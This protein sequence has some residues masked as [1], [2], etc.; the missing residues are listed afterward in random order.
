MNN[1]KKYQDEANESYFNAFGEDDTMPFADDLYADG[2]DASASRLAPSQPYIIKV[3]NTL[4]TD[5]TVTLFDSPNSIAGGSPAFGNALGITITSE[6][7]NT[8]YAQLL[9]QVMNQPFKVGRIEVFCS[10]VAQLTNTLTVTQNNLRGASASNSFFPILNP[11]QNVTTQIE[12]PFNFTVNDLTK[13]Q[14][15]LNGSVTSITFRFYP[16]TIFN[17]VKTTVEKDPVQS[18]GRPRNMAL[19]AN[20]VVVSNRMIG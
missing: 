2:A 8:T 6:I 12:V 5:T 10:T 15:T 1:F 11:L 3:A 18:Y 17:P 9:Y 16:E 13:F 4:T 7:P 14:F 20:P 19:Y